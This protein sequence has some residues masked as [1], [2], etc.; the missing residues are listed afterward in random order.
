MAIIE[1]EETT[2]EKVTK[3]ETNRRIQCDVCEDSWPE[4]GEMVIH[5][6][7][8]DRAKV[9]EFNSI[10]DLS[11]AIESYHTK[12]PIDDV[13]EADG[14]VDVPKSNLIPTLRE[15][16][17][18]TGTEAGPNVTNVYGTSSKHTSSKREE[19]EDMIGD[20][21]FYLKD[22]YLH[23]FMYRLK[24][25]WTAEETRHVCDDCYHIVF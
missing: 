7:S 15:E 5:E 10:Q 12:Q 16:L 13:I 21:K 6:F 4:D 19:L 17:S 8:V 14:V 24:V 3:T 22:G 20:D 18:L 1:Q 2:V 11:R 25:E 9:E 23:H